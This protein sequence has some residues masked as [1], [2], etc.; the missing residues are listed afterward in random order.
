[1]SSLPE[2]LVRFRTEL[3]DAIRRELEAPATARSNGWGARMLRAVRRRPGRTTLA[4]AAVAGAA[5]AALFVSSPW[6]SSPGFLEPAQA[7][8]F[9]ERAESALTQPAG[10]IVHFSAEWSRTSTRFGCTVTGPNEMWIDQASPHGWRR[11]SSDSVQD[12]AWLKAADSRT[13]ACSDWGTHEFGGDAH[14]GKD[15]G[16]NPMFVR[17]LRFV[18]PNTLRDAGAFSMTH[19]DPI[20]FL[21]TMINDAV[22]TGRGHDEG[23]TEI[24]GRAVRRVPPRLSP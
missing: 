13:I 11:I 2:S 10:T 22:A 17:Q 20:A 4:F 5:A 1:M 7:A 14:G 24:D 8:R 18:P 3:E 16:G 6:K 19:S 21:R 12:W 15:A 23:M 9:L